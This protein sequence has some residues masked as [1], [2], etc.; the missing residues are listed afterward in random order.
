MDPHKFIKDQPETTNSDTCFFAYPLQKWAIY[1]MCYN[2]TWGLISVPL[3]KSYDIPYYK[4][5]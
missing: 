3:Y 5:C 1:V 2:W 4:T